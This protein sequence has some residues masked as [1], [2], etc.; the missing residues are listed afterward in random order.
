MF[1][2][3]RLQRSTDAIQRR[4]GDSRTPERGRFSLVNTTPAHQPPYSSPD[5][6]LQIFLALAVPS[7]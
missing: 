1:K 6:P 4:N 3:K 2:E 7:A 5:I